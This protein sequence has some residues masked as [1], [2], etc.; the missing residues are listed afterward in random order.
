M[1]KDELQAGEFYWH[2]GLNCEVQLLVE[3]V[4][5]LN[6]PLPPWAAK[7]VGPI[8]SVSCFGEIIIVRTEML[9]GRARFAHHCA[10]CRFL[11]AFGGHDLYACTK[12]ASDELG[13]MILIRYGI[14]PEDYRSGA[15]GIDQEVL[16]GERR[17][18]MLSTPS[19]EPRVHEL[20]TW[21]VFFTPVV[22]GTKTFDL[23]KNDRDFA[24]GDY[25]L[26][27]EWSPR[28]GYSGRSIRREITYILNEPGFGVEPGY[29]VVGFKV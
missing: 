22:L 8:S 15:G 10:D 13:P 20:K 24:V 5:T 16:E 19:R 21:P 14:E 3:D 27:R 17:M 2:I 4:R 9:F 25:L 7:C 11:G 1:N 29:V 26:L 28:K 12:D 18:D 6:S 23:R